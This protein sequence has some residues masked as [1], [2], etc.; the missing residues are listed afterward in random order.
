M[1]ALHYN[2]VVLVSLQII[3]QR[4]QGL[5]HM[6][7]H[8][9]VLSKRPVRSIRPTPLPPIFGPKSCIGLLLYIV[10]VHSV[11]CAQNRDKNGT[12]IVL[13]LS[14]DEIISEGM[15]CAC[16]YKVLRSTSAYG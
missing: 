13:V 8:R 1:T 11:F 9:K 12:R 15:H 16:M 10:N 7:M 5:M 4:V 3:L 2:V 14:V 6:H